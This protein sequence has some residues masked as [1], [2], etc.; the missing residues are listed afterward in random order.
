M[1]Y[2]TY[3]PVKKDEVGKFTPIDAEKLPCDHVEL[4]LEEELKKRGLREPAHSETACLWRQKEM[5][6]LVRKIRY[7]EYANKDRRHKMETPAYDALFLAT[8]P[9]LIVENEEAYRLWRKEVE[10]AYTNEPLSE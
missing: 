6:P 10:K 9:S 1:K 2:L 8:L 4:P 3:S 7:Q 5:I